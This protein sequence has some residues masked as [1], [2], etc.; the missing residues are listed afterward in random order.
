MK[1]YKT[2]K[3]C[4]GIP[5]RK[6]D[7]RAAGLV[8]APKQWLYWIKKYG[9]VTYD[10]RHSDVRWGAFFID[11]ISTRHFQLKEDA[12]FYM[13]SPPGLYI[14]E[15]DEFFNKWKD[16]AIAYIEVKNKLTERTFIESIKKLQE[17]AKDFTTPLDYSYNPVCLGEV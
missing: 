16:S 5:I 6:L 7:G 3:K 9:F 11:P 12:N 13:D 4:R 8:K 15:I 17:Y 10:K 14:S 1:K 2:Q